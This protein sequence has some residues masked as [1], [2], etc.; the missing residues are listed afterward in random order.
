MAGGEPCRDTVKALL[1]K[2]EIV[3]SM[4]STNETLAEIYPG[5]KSGSASYGPF[6]RLLQKQ[7]QNET[8]FWSFSC[9]PRFPPVSVVFDKTDPD[10]AQHPFPNIRVP[11]MVGA[12]PKPLFPE[13][14]F[15]LYADSDVEESPWTSAVVP[16]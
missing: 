5:D 14:F 15:S 3:A 12:G 7:L 2:T 1:E 16:S 13:I 6:I 11:P 4:M 10:P 9:I 8:E